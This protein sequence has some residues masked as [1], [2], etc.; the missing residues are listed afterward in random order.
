MGGGFVKKARQSG[1]L[2]HP[3]GN[4]IQEKGIDRQS[5]AVNGDLN[6]WQTSLPLSGVHGNP[7]WHA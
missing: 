7:S 6:F 3:V 4:A 5:H 1:A 2:Q